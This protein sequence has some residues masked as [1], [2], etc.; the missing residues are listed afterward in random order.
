M[1][2]L[3][4]LTSLDLKITIEIKPVLINEIFIILKHYFVIYVSSSWGKFIMPIFS[5]HTN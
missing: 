1:L 2:L 5:D 4:K 3:K